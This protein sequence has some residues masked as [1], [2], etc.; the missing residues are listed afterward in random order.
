[1]GAR[2]ASLTGGIVAAAA[3]LLVGGVLGGAGFRYWNA[4]P[5]AAPSV[6]ASTVAAL[7]ALALA[8]VLLVEL[9]RSRA[10]PESV[11]RWAIVVVAALAGVLVSALYGPLPD[12]ARAYGGT[13]R[14]QVT[15]PIR[16][17]FEATTTVHCETVPG[18]DRVA[19]LSATALEPIATPAPRTPAPGASGLES[20]GLETPKPELPALALFLS[21]PGEQPASISISESPTDEPMTNVGASLEIV[22]GDRSGRATFMGLHTDEVWVGA[23]GGDLAGS[24][25]W[26]C[27]DRLPDAVNE[28]GG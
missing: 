10:N 4:L 16:A 25:R 7:A 3:V 6:E 14:L 20:P 22:A 28:P 18:T 5:S 8:I 26:T 17:K 2:T 9:L 27:S 15:S 19:W 21:I 13:V 1:M 24:V 12:N 11:D 23:D